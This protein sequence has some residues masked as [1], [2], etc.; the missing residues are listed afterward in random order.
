MSISKYKQETEIPAGEI[1]KSEQSLP[2]L[3]VVSTESCSDS[4]PMVRLADV[5]VGCKDRPEMGWMTTLAGT[6]LSEV[7]PVFCGAT[8]PASP[9][10]G[11]LR[12]LPCWSVCCKILGSIW[13]P[14][15]IPAMKIPY[16]RELRQSKS[17]EVHVSYHTCNVILLML[18]ASIPEI[19]TF[20][21]TK[22]AASCSWMPSRA[23]R[24]PSVRDTVK[25]PPAGQKEKR[26][27]ILWMLFK[28]KRIH[29]LHRDFQIP[30]FYILY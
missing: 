19:W 25:S 4:G 3:L 29:F 27:R 26:K 11:W 8:P 5:T 7:C 12:R 18:D 16:F 21:P 20:G 22:F 9:G 14:T 30:K 1:N 24:L 28:S 23:A 13:K 17:T 6:V 15:Q 10:N 2:L